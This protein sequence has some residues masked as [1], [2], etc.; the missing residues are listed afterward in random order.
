MANSAPLP[1]SVPHWGDLLLWQQSTFYAVGQRAAA[2]GNIYQATSAGTSA[3]AG[4]GPAGAGAGIVDGTVVWNYVAAA[5]T[6]W[7]QST[8]YAAGAVVS[9]GGNYYV[10]TGAGTSSGA[11]TGPSGTGGA[12]VDGTVVWAYTSTYVAQQTLPTSRTADLGAVSGAPNFAQ[13]QNEIF[14]QIT[15]WIYYVRDI[16]TRDWDWYGVANFHGVIN[17][18]ATLVA[19]STIVANGYSGDTAASIIYTDTVTTR[20]LWLSVLSLSPSIRIYLRG[21]AQTGIEFVVNAAWHDSGPNANK[22][23][24][25]LAGQNSYRLH[26]DSSGL[27]MDYVTAGAAPWADAAWV[28]NLNAVGSNLDVLLGTITGS[29]LV[30]NGNVTASA[31]ALYTRHLIGTDGSP[32]L[33]GF[34]TGAGTPVTGAALSGT[35]MGGSFQFTTGQ[36]GGGGSNPVANALICNLVL[37]NAMPNTPYVLL[38][39]ANLAAANLN[40]QPYIDF[41]NT[42][43][44]VVPIKA[45]S[46]ALAANTL[47]R[48][49]YQIV[50]T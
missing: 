35:D 13:Y 20:K 2:N 5:A 34:S 48:F 25:D 32:T 6:A 45:G 47:Y 42:T 17:A 49:N 30:S 1:S 21:G 24:A 26:L 41:V 27:T 12:I 22:W 3:G 31:G 38:Y 43:S 8:V 50:G 40:N 37:A 11:G 15:K 10:A 16:P 23:V 7:A 29:A 44:S 4:T 9:N 36:A 18:L 33:S 28:T 14:G 46:V 19:S 39:P